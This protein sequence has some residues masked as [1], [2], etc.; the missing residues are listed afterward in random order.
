MRKNYDSRV[1]SKVVIGAIKGKKTIAQ[2]QS[3][4]SSPCVD[5]R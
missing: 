1:K 5:V 2:F 4:S 3:R